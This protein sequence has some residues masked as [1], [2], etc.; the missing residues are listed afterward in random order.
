[1]ENKNIVRIIEKIKKIVSNGMS[2]ERRILELVR[3]R[4]LTGIHSNTTSADVLWESINSHKFNSDHCFSDF[5]SLTKESVFGLYKIVFDLSD[6]E[7]NFVL[8]EFL[9]AED[10]NC[11]GA[12]GK[13]FKNAIKTIVDDDINEN[14]LISPANKLITLSFELVT[15]HPQVDFTLEIEDINN[16][17][18][19][20]NLLFK[21]KKNVRIL[22][23]NIIDDP[24]DA[25]EYRTLIHFPDF[26]KRFSIDYRSNTSKP[27]CTVDQ[28]LMAAY[29]DNLPNTRVFLIVPERV[30]FASGS[31]AKYRQK[32][33]ENNRLEKVVS[34]PPRIFLPVTS[35]KM[36]ILE[37][38]VR[39]NSNE[40][41]TAISYDWNDQRLSLLPKETFLVSIDSIRELNSWNLQLYKGIDLFGKCK[42]ETAPLEEFSTDIF[43]GAPLINNSEL[44]ESG[45]PVRVIESADI[46]PEIKSSDLSEKFVSSLR[47]ID[48]YELRN[49]DIIISVRGSIVK[50]GIFRCSEGDKVYPSPNVAVIRLDKNKL[51]PRFL[52][53]YLRSPFGNNLIEAINLGTIIKAISVKDLKSIQIPLVRVNDQKVAM[54]EYIEAKKMY[55]RH[56]LVLNQNLNLARQSLYEKMGFSS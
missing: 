7:F 16:N 35:I 6:D 36:N 48:R 28:V 49:D 44:H 31:F 40:S 38:S 46:K 34:L 1:M 9:E 55:E 18:H 8:L 23:K 54:D 45:D 4:H 21:G 5:S 17:R 41:V 25:F 3:I 42:S 19:L 47:R 26:T 20:L 13:L 30:V 29:V 14:C 50:F 53:E 11:E 15:S 22:E 39:D 43:R 27:K 32:I 10:K 24:V 52:T 56:L 37:L 51:D 12:I 33:I 2:Q